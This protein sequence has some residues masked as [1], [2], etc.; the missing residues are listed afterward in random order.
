MIR[1]R[2]CGQEFEQPT[3]R[4]SDICQT[5]TDTLFKSTMEEPPEEFDDD[6]KARL[7]YE[8]AE[9]RAYEA[10]DNGKSRV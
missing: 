8:E 3:C 4:E 6:E 7:Q 5:C 2:I 10:E 9:C 1:C